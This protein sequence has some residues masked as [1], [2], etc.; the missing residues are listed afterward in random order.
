MNALLPFLI[1]Y[2]IPSALAA[3][4]PRSDQSQTEP[5]DLASPLDGKVLICTPE[6]IRWVSVAELAADDE[7]SSDKQNT[8]C[9]ICYTAAHGAQH[10]L[11]PGM[12]YVIDFR[13]S[14]LVHTESGY[15]CP[16]INTRSRSF[17]ARAPPNIA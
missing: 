5:S 12:L 8:F 10:I 16:V 14:K 11:S 9:P 4:L 1:L 2:T 6:G 7:S 15:T 13:V 3:E 17:Y